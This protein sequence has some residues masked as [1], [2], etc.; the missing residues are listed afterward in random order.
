MYSCVS[1]ADLAQ[2]FPRRPQLH[3]VMI[4]Q[5]WRFQIWNPGNKYDEGE[6]TDRGGQ[7]FRSFLSGCSGAWLRYVKKKKIFSL[8]NIVYIHPKST[9]WMV[10]ALVC[11]CLY[12]HMKW[13]ITVKVC[14][15]GH[16]FGKAQCT[17]YKLE[18][19]A[20]FFIDLHTLEKL[21]CGTL[22]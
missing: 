17:L 13:T 11:V 22:I 14:C 2:D 20:S 4:P 10:I 7:W 9:W 1:P 15:L 3:M 5:I 12:W 16:R 21:C 18:H 8:T 19:Q 6:V